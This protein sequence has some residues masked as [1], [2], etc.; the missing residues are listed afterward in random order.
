M[1]E[2]LEDADSTVR[3]L[4]DRPSAWQ[5]PGGPDGH[6]VV[7]QPGSPDLSALFVR[8]RSRAPSSQMP[9]LGTVLRDQEAVDTIGRWIS[10]VSR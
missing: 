2:M 6:S 1:R 9:P 5:V 10:N 7:V 4:L 8:L 3:N